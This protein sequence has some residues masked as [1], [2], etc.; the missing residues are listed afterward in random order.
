MKITVGHL[1]ILAGVG[2]YGV[3]AASVARRTRELGIR[4]A[5]GADG[6]ALLRMV[7]RQ[8]ITPVV[9]GIGIGLAGAAALTHLL[10]SQLYGITGKDLP[11]FGGASLLLLVVAVAACYLP[12]RRAVTAD[13]VT[14]LR[15]E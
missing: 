2:I 12:A 11:S 5:L 14:A 10:A 6:R 13:P 1:V 8:G 9:W 4:V 7:L 3:T 15:C